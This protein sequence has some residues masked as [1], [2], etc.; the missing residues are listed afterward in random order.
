VDRWIGG[1]VDRWIGGSV[2]RWMIGH[3][4]QF[5]CSFRLMS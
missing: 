4:F 2:D 3:V 1:S 5:G